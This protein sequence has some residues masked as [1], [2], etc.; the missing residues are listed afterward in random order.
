MRV[1]GS[2]EK[3]QIVMNRKGKA[4]IKLVATGRDYADFGES[5]LNTL[6]GDLEVWEGG[7][8]LAR[9]RGTASLERRTP[10]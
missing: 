9:A 10:V 1:E 7:R 8:L 4:P 6:T 2:P 5:I 3:F